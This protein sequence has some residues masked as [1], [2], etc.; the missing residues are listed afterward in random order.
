MNRL[1]HLPIHILSI[2]LPVDIATR[3]LVLQRERRISNLGR[4]AVL[5]VEETCLAHVLD[6]GAGL[7]NDGGLESHAGAWVPAEDG[8][9][10]STGAA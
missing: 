6:F 8:E 7:T 1:T 4:E 10:V 9:W 3:S 5:E 2:V